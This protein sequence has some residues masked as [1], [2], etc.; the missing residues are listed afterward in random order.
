MKHGKSNA[1]D[2]DFPWWILPDKPKKVLAN[3]GMIGST[4]QGWTMTEP[5]W[6][7]TEEQAQRYRLWLSEGCKG[8]WMETNNRY[9]FKL[10]DDYNMF[11]MYCS[12]TE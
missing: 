10:E 1:P 7:K 4:P 12:L 9:F 2:A 11:L 8:E 6:H 5:D 3:R